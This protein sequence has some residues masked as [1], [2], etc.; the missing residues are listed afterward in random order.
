MTDQNVGNA[1]T[2]DFDF[3][4]KDTYK[5]T[6]PF[7]QA[8]MEFE[9]RTGIKTDI[10][11]GGKVTGTL[12]SKGD[13]Y[14][15]IDFRGK[16]SVCIDITAQESMLLAN[17]EIGS[18]ITVLITSITDKD[19]FEIGGS[20]Y[21]L[22]MIEMTDFLNS[23]YERRG[24][25][26]GIPAELNHAGYNVT[27]NIEDQQ[28]S[29]FMP[30]LLTDV[31]KLPDPSSII[32]TEIEFYLEQARKDGNTSYIASRKAYLLNMAIKEKRNLKKG[33]QYDGFVTG[34]TDFAVFVQFNKCLTG[35]I[36]K[37]NLTE[38]A[39]AMLPNIPAGTTIEFYV[40]DIM[41]DKLFLTQV[42]RDSLWDSIAIND[43]LPGTISSIKDFGVMVDLDYETKGLLHK[44][45]LPNPVDSYKKGDKVNVLVTNV[46]KNNRQITLALK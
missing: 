10:E 7:G 45:V 35:M 46:N 20:L 33:G 24:V 27:I 23:V 13:K 8:L 34:C 17:V 6:N 44:S 38:Q 26:T 39:V 3:A 19:T 30:H 12:I 15:F 40:K 41:K 11:V 36:H 21:Q 16:T 2:L 18:E 32:G 28:L 29:L 5:D 43:V 25:L 1:S 31:N 42:L 14:A 37:S 22:K 4:T 9:A